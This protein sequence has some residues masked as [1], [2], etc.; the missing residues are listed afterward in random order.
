MNKRSKYLILGVVLFAVGIGL[1]IA[2]DFSPMI[3]VETVQVNEKSTDWYRT[4]FFYATAGD[5]VDINVNVNG[6]ITAK[7]IVTE[8]NGTT[9]FGEV[10][11]YF[12]RYDVPIT[13]DDSYAVQI[14]TRAWPWPSTYVDLHGVVSLE[15]PVLQFYPVGFVA[16]G[17]T[18]LGGI[19]LAIGVLLYTQQYLNL[20][21]EKKLRA[22][23]FCKRRVSIEKPVCPYCGFDIVNSVVCEYCG[24]FY[25]RSAQNCPNCGAKKTNQ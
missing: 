23:P 14:W 25:N 13:T 2:I 21:K 7:L 17:M 1:F 8:Q 15:R 24:H 4:G 5:H 16:S 18:A 22:C 12:L 6:D 11:G 19:M 3:S 10:N 9:L 20:Q